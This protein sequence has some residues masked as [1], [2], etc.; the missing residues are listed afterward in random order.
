MAPIAHSDTPQ[1]SKLEVKSP[2]QIRL[3]FTME[4]LL[5]VLF[6]IRSRKFARMYATLRRLKQ[7]ENTCVKLCP[8]IIVSLH[9]SPS[10]RNIQLTH[11]EFSTVLFICTGVCVCIVRVWCIGYGFPFFPSS[12]TS[13]RYTFSCQMFQES[14][15]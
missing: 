7:V 4:L 3:N 11:D 10:T 5:V 6:M 15:K 8:V 14:C 2:T 9:I 12:T 13:L 1:W